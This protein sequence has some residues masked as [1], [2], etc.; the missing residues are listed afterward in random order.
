MVHFYLFCKVERVTAL[1]PLFYQDE[2]RVYPPS[3]GPVI[4]C[5]AA[6][7]GLPAGRDG[8]KEQGSMGRDGRESPEGEKSEGIVSQKN[9]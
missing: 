5:P 3:P 9:Y 8:R 7:P 1:P 2:T 6:P 4:Q